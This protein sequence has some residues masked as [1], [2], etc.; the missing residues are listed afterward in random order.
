MPNRQKSQKNIILGNVEQP[1]TEGFRNLSRFARSGFGGR[2]E[3]D[4]CRSTPSSSFSLRF[5]GP[6]APPRSYVM[7][8][9]PE[10]ETQVKFFADTCEK[11][12][13]I[14]AKNFD[15]FCPLITRKSGRKKFHENPPHFPRG[16]KQNSFTARF[17][18][19]WAP[20]ICPR[21]YVPISAPTNDAPIRGQLSPQDRKQ[22]PRNLP[23]R[24]P[25][26]CPRKCPRKCPL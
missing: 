19:W 25:Q 2:N 17:W 4:R 8:E 15:D 13:E 1:I 22:L 5:G 16:M 21:S 12:S 3:A 20:I 18:E 11:R 10:S 14:L 7:K 23:R 26:R 6:I 24:C 9:I